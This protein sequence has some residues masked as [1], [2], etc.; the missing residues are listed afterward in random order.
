MGNKTDGFID[1]LLIFVVLFCMGTPL[2]DS[3][4]LLIRFGILGFSFLIMLMRKD[5][6]IDRSAFASTFALAALPFITMILTFD[7]HMNSYLGMAVLCISTLFVVTVIDYKS[8]EEKYTKLL[9]ALC[10]FSLGCYILSNIVPAFVQALP[11]YF[12][13][14]FKHLFHLQYFHNTTSILGYY[15]MSTRN[16]GMFREPGI[17]QIYINLAM[18]LELKRSDKLSNIRM[19]VFVITLLTTFSS[20]GIIA[21]LPIIIAFLRKSLSGKSMEEKRKL[22]FL[23]L[24]ILFVFGFFVYRNY[25]ILFAEKFAQD[26]ASAASVTDRITCLKS[27]LNLFSMSPL[28][29][30][31]TTGMNNG[32]IGSECSFTSTAALYGFL[33]PI[34]LIVGLIKFAYKSSDCNNRNICFCGLLS[35]IISFSLQ[36]TLLYPGTLI[37][38]IYGFSRSDGYTGEE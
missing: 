18:F 21:G 27:D 3:Y 2:G 35:F 1:Y 26:G 9:F 31:G 5:L 15:T 30:V 14:E 7:R 17:F 37:L 4:S 8:Y 23:V 22:L 16:T 20:S 6:C 10:S 38:I 33:Y 19:L 32:G 13:L 25:D 12:G 34:I 11:Y 28:W 29:G 36:N 24:V